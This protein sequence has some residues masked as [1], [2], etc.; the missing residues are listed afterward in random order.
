MK[1]DYAKQYVSNNWVRYAKA[2]DFISIEKLPDK[3]SYNVGETDY[4]IAE[5]HYGTITNC[6]YLVD[7]GYDNTDATPLTAEQMK[8][9][10]MFAGFDFE[11]VWVLDPYANHPYPQLKNNIQ[12]MKQSVEIARVVTLPKKTNYYT[13]DELNLTGA[14]LE[15]VYISGKTEIIPITLD[16]ISGYEPSVTGKQ[17]LTVTFEE[18]TSTIDINVEQRPAVTKLTLVSQPNKND[19]LV[20]SVFDFSGAQIKVEYDNGANEVKDVTVAMTTGGDINRIGKQTITVT[21]E[22]FSVTFDVEVSQLKVT[23]VSISQKPNKLVYLEGQNID[24][25]GLELAVTYNNG[26]TVKVKSGYTIE[27]YLNIPGKH[28]VNVIYDNKTTT[29][30]VEVQAKSI[31][32]VELRQGPTKTEYYEGDSFDKT[33]IVLVATYDTTEVEI[34]E[35]YDVLNFDSTIGTKTVTLAYEGF[36]VSFTVKVNALSLTGIYIDQYPVKTEYIENEQL[37]TTGLVVKAIYNNGDVITIDN[38]AISGFV[39]EP[40]DYIIAIAFEG[41]TCSYDVTVVEK[42]LQDVRITMPNKLTYKMGENFDST[43]LTVTAYYNNGQVLTV[44]SYVLSG[45]DSFTTGTKEITVEFGGFTRSFAVVVCERVNVET[46]GNITVGNIIARL[47]DTIV[48]PVSASNNSGIAGFTHTITFAANN[49]EFVSA[50][51][52]GEFANGTVIVNDEKLADGKLTVLWFGDKNVEGDGVVYNLTFK[53]R[54]T[55]TDGK[56]NINISF[57]DNDNVNTTGGNV[58]F[59]IVNGFVDIRSYW[60]GDLNGDREFAMVDLL[61]LAQYVSGKEMTL[62]DKQKLSADVNEDGIID[63]H[64]VVMLNQWL[65]VADM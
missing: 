54:E 25:T 26:N 50:V 21:I 48:I 45:F 24:L 18:K 47:G 36:S 27:G 2:C 9:Q 14:T 10:S 44:E 7:S 17:T 6:Y 63:I 29:F 49:L 61:Q 59:G 15:V 58:L 16:M 55:A 5:N 39:S 11:N 40:G 4:A 13:G 56:T 34:I 28:I 60:L 52:M 46:D 12:D 33:G 37:D 41:K 20:G 3:L 42:V 32:S 35:N 43:G 65:L 62:T 1:N 57:N 31:V 38:Y 51:A 8:I 53:V 22:G 30:E 64:D 23:E 19:F